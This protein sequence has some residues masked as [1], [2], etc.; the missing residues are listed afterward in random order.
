MIVQRIIGKYCSCKLCFI[1]SV[2]GWTLQ[3][4]AV[5]RHFSARGSPSCRLLDMRQKRVQGQVGVWL[6]KSMCST[7]VP[8]CNAIK[9]VYRPRCPHSFSL[10]FIS[11]TKC[12]LPG[13]SITL[14]P[15]TAPGLQLWGRGRAEREWKVTTGLLK[16]IMSLVDYRASSPS[17]FLAGGQCATACM[18]ISPARDKGG[19]AVGRDHM[20]WALG[21]KAIWSYSCWCSPGASYSTTQ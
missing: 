15:L 1:C 3:G 19:R 21:R 20:A 2:K 8:L 12:P 18:L 11:M 5:P 13:Q 14:P 7:E 10:L 4:L 6:I 9:Q 17:L 16:V